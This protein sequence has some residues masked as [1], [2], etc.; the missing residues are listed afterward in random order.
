[1]SAPIVVSSISASQQLIRTRQT[2]VP[3]NPK[4]LNVLGPQ[5]AAEAKLLQA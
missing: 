1:M 3:S 4:S 2:E 5:Y